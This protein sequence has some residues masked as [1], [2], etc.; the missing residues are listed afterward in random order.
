MDDLKELRARIVE[1][2]SSI[3]TLG[4]V[5]DELGDSL[6]K[7]NL[8]VERLQSNVPKVIIH[9]MLVESDFIVLNDAL[10]CVKEYAEEVSSYGPSP[11]DLSFKDL[12]E[13][14]ERL[15]AM[16]KRLK[17]QNDVAPK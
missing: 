14:I 4:K 15:D 1:F 12:K 13:L 5:T 9:D 8:S 2:Q 7:A 3:E 16:I 17:I 11:S 6:F 10:N